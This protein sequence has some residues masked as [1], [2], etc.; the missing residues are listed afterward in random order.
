MAAVSVRN[1]TKKYG[2]FT[3][4][5]GVSFDVQAG[6]VFALLGPNG[7]GKSSIVRALVG[8]HA[9]TSGTVEIAGIDMTANPVAAKE[10]LGYLPEVASLY[11]SLTAREHLTLVARLHR[12]PGAAAASI[13]RILESL[14]LLPFADHVIASFSKGM[15]QKTALAGAILADPE[16]YILDEPASG[17]DAEA[18]LI[19][20][21][22]VREAAARGK[23]VL[24]TS[25]LL[26]V[27]EKVADRAAILVQGKMV[28]IGTLEEIRAQ[29]GVRGDLAS[30]FATLVRSED[31]SLRAKA[32]LDS[33]RRSGNR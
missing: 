2:A 33:A 22:L 8:I 20:R 32:L 3:A 1:F 19:L 16:V 25:H 24:Y 17:L 21:S 9:P 4:V 27:V 23:A 13:E 29:A 11:E 30:V 31:P 15:K 14:D 18:A 12:L 6:E 7:A 28:A 26:D 10:A 5:D